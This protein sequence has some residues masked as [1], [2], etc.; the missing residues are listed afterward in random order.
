MKRL[1]YILIPA[2]LVAMCAIAEETRIGAGQIIVTSANAATPAQWTNASTFVRK[3]TIL[4]KKTAR[5]ANTGDIYIG[6]TSGND[7]QAFRLSSDGQAVIEA[8]PGTLINLADWYLD[9][10]TAN[11]GI[12]LIYH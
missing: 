11:D 5:T 8:T 2:L 10:T 7:T 12:V 1:I 9:V 3:V 6:P 4:A